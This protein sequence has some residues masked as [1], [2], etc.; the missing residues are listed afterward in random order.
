MCRLPD[1][2]EAITFANAPYLDFPVSF[3]QFAEVESNSLGRFEGLLNGPIARHGPRG[4]NAEETD[5][6][7]D[8]SAKDERISGPGS[9]RPIRQRMWAPSGIAV[10]A[11]ISG[12]M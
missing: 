3:R 11:D 12:I 7:T 4:R 6:D 9:S 10:Q 8:A 2:G 5:D 1:V